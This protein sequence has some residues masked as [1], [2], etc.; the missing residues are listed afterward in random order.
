MAGPVASPVRP[1]TCHG[2]SIHVQPIR[3]VRC[4]ELPAG[5]SLSHYAQERPEAGTWLSHTTQVQ[6][7]LS[8]PPPNMLSTAS[9]CWAQP[10]I[11]GVAFVSNTAKPSPLVEGYQGLY[12]LEKDNGTAA[13]HEC[14][15]GG[16]GAL[17]IVGVAGTTLGVGGGLTEHCLGVVVGGFL[18]CTG[19]AV[20]V[21]AGVRAC[22]SWCLGY[23][24]RQATALG[25]LYGAR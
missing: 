9:Y 3:C 8:A 11:K 19:E 24:F 5:H 13:G 22:P 21:C 20:Q 18:A 15:E 7:R 6:E 10:T 25:R 14:Q 12:G 23:P 1:S 2:V 4:I 17:C 16:G